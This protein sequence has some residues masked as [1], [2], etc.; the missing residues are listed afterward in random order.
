MANLSFQHHRRQV[1][2]CGL[3]LLT[4]CDT[5]PRLPQPNSSWQAVN[6]FSEQVQRLPLHH[7][8]RYTVRTTDHTL[9]QLLTRWAQES[10]TQLAYNAEADFSLPQSLADLNTPELGTAIVQL[11]TIYRMHGVVVAM[12]ANHTLTVSS[13]SKE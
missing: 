3:L 2:A 5:K 7:A 13:L 1:I 6:R 12:D 9:R 10:N 4:A 8:H 11:N